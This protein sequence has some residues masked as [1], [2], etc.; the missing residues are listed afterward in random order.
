[1]EC[2]H[3]PDACRECIQLGPPPTTAGCRLGSV[4]R[5]MLYRRY[6]PREADLWPLAPEAED[7]EGSDEE[8]C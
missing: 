5:G 2:E 1:M 8:T 7:E 6:W 3:Y 4:G